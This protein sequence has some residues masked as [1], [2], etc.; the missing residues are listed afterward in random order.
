M[1]EHK[2]VSFFLFRP[3]LTHHLLRDEFA[4]KVSSQALGHIPPI[5]YHCI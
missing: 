4:P 5:V 1:D 2:S 3:Q